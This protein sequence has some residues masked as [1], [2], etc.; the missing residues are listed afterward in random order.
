[1]VLKNVITTE[2]LFK[3]EPQFFP[4]KVKFCLDMKRKTVAVNC[5]MH[6]DMEYELFDDGS[7]MRDIF[8]GNIIKSPVSVEWEAHPNIARNR[9]RGI[10]MGRLITD[11]DIK[12]Q[13]LDILTHWIR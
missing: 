9:E 7:D 3:M 12:Q 2:E 10:G 11:E 1:M 13:L 4:D 6:T 8:G 5:E